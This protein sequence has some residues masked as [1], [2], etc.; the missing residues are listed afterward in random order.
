M[1]SNV[2]DFP[3]IARLRARLEEQVIRLQD[4]YEKIHEGYSLMESLEEKVA[5][6]EENYQKTLMEYATLVG[7]NKVEVQFLEY[8]N[9]LVINL[10][11]GEIGV[12]ILDT[13]KEDE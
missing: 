4:G 10:E 2:V 13:K 7:P 1:V 11:T 3:S 9:S 6:V 8:S 12:G 5:E